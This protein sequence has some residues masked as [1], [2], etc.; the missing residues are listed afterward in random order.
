MNL[1]IWIYCRGIL[2]RGITG[3]P[4]TGGIYRTEQ[5]LAKTK[6][7]DPIEIEEEGTS[8]LSL[9]NDFSYDSEFDG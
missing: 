2:L 7:A 3:A 5:N 9:F 4:L 1:F 6:M 8:I